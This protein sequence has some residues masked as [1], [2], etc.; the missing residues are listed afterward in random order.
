MGEKENSMNGLEYFKE[1]MEKS[2]AEREKREEEQ[3]AESLLEMVGVYRRLWREIRAGLLEE[4]VPE[5]LVDEVTLSFIRLAA[6][7]G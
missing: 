7:N 3:R 6:N 5:E 2:K 4:G 1:M